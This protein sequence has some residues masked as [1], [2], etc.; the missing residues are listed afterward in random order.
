MSSKSL[1]LLDTNILIE[2]Y[3][4][5]YAFDI[6]PSFWR[7]IKEHA[8]AGQIISIDRV[9]NELTTFPDQDALKTWAVSEFNRWFVSTDNDEVISSYRDII[10]WAVSQTQYTDAAK[11]EF[12]SIADSWLIAA[13]KTYNC[14]LVTHELYD[15]N[16]KRKIPIPNVC[17]NF[18]IPYMNTF[19]MLR[20]L[21]ATLGH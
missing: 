15:A 9:L 7:L 19:E 17:R 6:A 2:A 14:I 11:A 21:N 13:A 8:E 4:R 1:Y 10:N 18:N 5:Y 20:S 3:K 12:A 16:I